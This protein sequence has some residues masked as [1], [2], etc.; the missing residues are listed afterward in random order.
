MHCSRDNRDGARESARKKESYVRSYAKASSAGSTQ[1][2]ATGLG[3][4]V[5]GAFA[6]RGFSQG[7]DGSGARSSGRRSA[8][9][10]SC[11]LAI[12]TALLALTA[13]AASAAGTHPYQGSFGPDGVSSPTT[14]GNVQAV[15][16]DQGSGDVYVFDTGKS[17]LFKFDAAGEPANFTDLTGNAI[18]G[19]SGAANAENQLAV[20]P[21]SS[22][23]GTAGD[24]YLANNRPGAGVSIYSPGG[25][26][27]GEIATGSG[28]VCGVATDPSGHVFVGIYGS[29][30]REYVP[31]ANP[32]TDGDKAAESNAT[33][34]NTCN[35]AADG[36]GNVYAANYEGTKGVVKLE[37]L[38]DPE[39][40]QVDPTASTLAIDP[41]TNDLYADQI[42]AIAQYEASGT[43]VGTF[44]SE[45]L[46]TSYGVGIDGSSGKVYAGDSSR[47]RIFGPLVT[48]PDVVTTAAGEAGKSTAVLHGTVDPD[49]VALTGC[50]FEYG[51]TTSASFEGEAP[52]SPTAGQIP[53][54]SAVHAVSA[55]LSNLQPNST[56]RFRLV[57]TNVNGVSEGKDLTFTTLGPPQ[58]T[59]VRALNASQSAVTLEGKVNPSGFGASYRIEWGPTASYGHQAPAEFEPYLGEGRQPV[60]VSAKLT[61]LSAE[62]IYHYRIVASSSAGVTTG[63]DQLAET[64]N[65]CGLLEARCFELV[66]RGEAGPVAIPGEEIASA[67]M[68]YQA[69]TSGPGLAYPVEA[70][71]PDSTK[72]AEVLYRGLRGPDE[73]ESTQ[74]SA[75]ISGPNEQA[76]AD[77]GNG[78]VEFIANDLSCGFQRS[79][80]LLTSDPGTRLVREYGGNNLYRFNPDGSRTAVT[81]LA[82]ENPKSSS[83]YNVGGAA[84]NCRKVVFESGYRY[85]GVETAGDAFGNNLY[86]WDEGTLRSVGHVPAPG[87]GEVAV[88]ATPGTGP[89]RLKD[90][91]NVV[92][93]DGSRVFFV[94]ERKT[95]PNP[96][97]IGKFGIFVRENGTTTRDLSLSETSTP[98]KGATYQ[99]ATPDGSKVFFTAN[100]GLTAETSSGS[101]NDLYVYDLESEKL[102]DLSVE[103]DTGG[104]QV[105]G[106][107]AAS[108]DGSHVYF[109]ARGQ[110]V[111]GRGNT[112]AE[113][114]AAG[115]YSIYGEHDGEYSYVGKVEDNLASV[116]QRVIVTF[117]GEWASQ[118]TPDGRYLL[119]ESDLNL[120]GYES[121]GSAEAYLYD[122]QAG[123]EGTICLSCR[124]DGQ[125]SVGAH[126]GA[127]ENGYR[128]ATLPTDESINNPPHPPRYLAQREGRPLVFFSSADVLAP[129]A[130]EGQN[131]VYGWT[132]GQV[133]RLTSAE[134]GQ[135]TFAFS[136]YFANPGGASDNGSDAYF[137][138]PETLNREDG[139]KRLSIYD[140][141][142]SGGYPEPPLPTI[143]C[144]P[145]A[146]G[147]CQGPSQGGASVPGAA[148]ATFN[149]PGNPKQTEPQKKKKSKKK[150]KKHTKKKGSGKQARHANGNRRA[151]K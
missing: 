65:S 30:I 31:S 39:A 56:Y 28:E 137:A 107:V 131:N 139:D 140:A 3:R 83:S 135:Q 102:T 21:P 130:V 111:P 41:A 82:P 60:R 16:V 80:Q 129:G 37:G 132:H 79:N 57:A 32:V 55:S 105:A 149:G 138:T 118:T 93:P 134:E 95:S 53:A 128:Y 64:L 90:S 91:Q 89:G 146:E 66:S 99:W 35:V 109:A 22:P 9:A 75:P 61:G 77:S 151:G 119:F 13:G 114:K 115:L 49:S 71:Y 27:L 6:T 88:S 124:P 70:G 141:R 18:E 112:L 103:H 15:A 25:T 142:I 122:S 11:S 133:Y 145:T 106:F 101:G 86:E 40:A 52:C 24:I 85:P 136:G 29:P 42:N 58:L 36:L 121:G 96:A 120:T 14:F 126:G 19:V 94:A 54:D 68:H 59:E 17:A 26:K 104:A 76:G 125:L 50:K 46:T 147:S 2:Q 81:K 38:T 110:L 8:F 47:V 67:E 12:F 51:L 33:L 98:D 74:L 116:L 150:S 117:Q 23:G 127:A 144:N 123:S 148:S 72:G 87:G 78:P 1:R 63:P 97:E 45:Q 113:N 48:L 20:A 5:R 92:S 100:A 69:K 108:P 73:W 34:P 10:F 143:P 62:T 4:I 44:G 84:Q 7:E 43:L